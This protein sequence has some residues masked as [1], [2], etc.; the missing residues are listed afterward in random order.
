MTQRPAKQAS[1]VP[2]FV[3][4]NAL[5]HDADPD[6]LRIAPRRRML[7][8][9]I[10]AYSGRHCTIPCTVRDISDGGARLRVTSSLL[11]PDTFEL[12]IESEG[13]EA[14]CEVVWRDE[15]Q[16]GV[17][18]VGAPRLVT[19]RMR[20]SVQVNIPQERQSIRRQKKQD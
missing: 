11:A 19:P 20:Q 4:N 5:Q 17:R 13:L 1:V 9:G 15:S 8:S 2:L 7:K 16:I 6:E 3:G 18:F 14:D 10:V 12:I